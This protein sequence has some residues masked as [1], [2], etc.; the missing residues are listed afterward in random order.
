[1]TKRGEFL[2]GLQVAVLYSA[3]AYMNHIHK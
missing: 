1:M 3:L 2:S